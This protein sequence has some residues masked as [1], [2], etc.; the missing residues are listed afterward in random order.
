MRSRNGA[1][2]TRRPPSTRQTE[3]EILEKLRAI[4]VRTAILLIA[5]RLSAVR[6]ADHIVV[7]EHGQAPEGAPRGADG[8]AHDSARSAPRPPDT[9]STIPCRK[10][11][12]AHSDPISP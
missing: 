4:P 8:A 11:P 1:C 2:G 6:V 9:T 5:H 10:R 7:L 12:D 3:A